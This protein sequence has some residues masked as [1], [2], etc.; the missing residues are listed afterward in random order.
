MIRKHLIG[1]IALLL[2]MGFFSGCGTPEGKDVGEADELTGTFSG[3][4]GYFSFYPEKEVLVSLSEDYLWLLEGKENDHTYGY[5]F[6]LGNEE[7]S[8]DKAEA[9]YLHDGSATFA[10]I[11]CIT[12][13]GKITLLPGGQQILVFERRTD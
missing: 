5:V 7:C 13:E 1:A 12:E 10:M 3:P 11:N 8:Y 2:I 6:I 4:D 9:I